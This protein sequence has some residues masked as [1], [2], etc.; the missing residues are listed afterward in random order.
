MKLNK[1]KFK[2]LPVYEYLVDKLESFLVSDD[3]IEENEAL[4]IINQL[5]NTAYVIINTNEF[6]A[7]QNSLDKSDFL[8]LR[9]KE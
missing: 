6:I 5:Y 1:K 7:I 9:W 3:S 8:Y 2:K 4:D